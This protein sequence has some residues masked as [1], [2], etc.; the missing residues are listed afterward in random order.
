MYCCAHALSLRY[1]LGSRLGLT[2]WAHALGSRLGLTPWAHALGSRLGLTPWAHAL[3]SRLALTPCAHAL[4]S[5]L[6]L[7][8]CTHAL[9][10]RLALTPCAHTL[11]SHL[12]LT[13]CVHALTLTPCAAHALCRSRLVPL[14]PS[15]AHALRHLRLAPLTPCAA[16]GLRRLR[17]APLTPC[18]AHALRRSRLAPLTP[19][20]AH[21]L[22]R[23][24]LASLTPCAAHALR[25]SRLALLTPCAAHALRRS[26]LALYL[27]PPPRFHG[28]NSKV[29]M[30]NRC[31]L[32]IDY[33][34]LLSSSISSAHCG[35][36]ISSTSCRGRLRD[37]NRT[38]SFPGRCNGCDPKLV[39]AIRIQVLNGDP[40]DVCRSG[41]LVV[42]AIH[43]DGR[44]GMPE[45]WN[46]RG[47]SGMIWDH[48]SQTCSKCFIV[49]RSAERTFCLPDSICQ[50]ASKAGT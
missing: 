4:R 10:S 21:A 15:A 26:R 33:A 16:Y 35:I 12:A 45:N 40:H 3:G 27:V 17:L 46:K 1:A 47:S 22:R 20:T 23:S 41:I 49:L 19:C 37:D 38:H 30:P 32:C 48:F 5:R 18:A 50:P 2:P 44:V 36:I 43:H 13:S 39:L 42:A 31:R 29:F 28:K 9:R 24:R 34:T 8:P 6:A 25:R 7:T 11:R 14:T